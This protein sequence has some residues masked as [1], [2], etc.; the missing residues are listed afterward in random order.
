MLL[1]DIPPQEDYGLNMYN[2]GVGVNRDAN[3]DDINLAPI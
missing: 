1:P 2:F 3:L